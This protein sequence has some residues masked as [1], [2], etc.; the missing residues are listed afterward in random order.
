MKNI[1][2]GAAILLSVNITF[3]QKKIVALWETKGLPTPESTLFVARDQ[4]LYVS[5]IDGGSMDKDGK[6]GVAK[7]GLD[8]QVKD[9]NWV[10]GMD[11][12]KGLHLYEDLLYVADL[13]AVL[14]VDVITGNEIRRIEVPGSIMLNDVT[15]DDNGV[16]YV[17][18]TRANKIFEL[19][20]NKAA[21]FLDNTSNVNGLKFHKGSLYALVDKEL[22]QINAAKQTKVLA[23]GFELPADGLEPVGEGD[24][25]VSC[26]GGLIY[27]VYADGRKDL[28]LDVRGKQNTADIGFDPKSNTLYVP[29][30]NNNSVQAFKLQ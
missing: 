30:F 16:I 22:W 4:V 18:D 28:L 12:P 23:K 17:S 27:Y 7:L 2:I 1:F 13:T 19:R 11:A 9:L 24:F 29:T 15:G 14:V 26:W 21:L 6:G 3:A 10:T 5:L 8:G 25:L 20:N